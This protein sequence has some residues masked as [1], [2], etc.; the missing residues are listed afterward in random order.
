MDT[1]AN[2]SESIFVTKNASIPYDYEL[3][4]VIPKE[5]MAYTQGLLFHKGQLYESTGQY[6]RSSVRI[7]DHNTGKV[8]RKSVV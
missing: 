3:V 2:Q 6:G 8:D 5:P 1:N 7:V 4:R